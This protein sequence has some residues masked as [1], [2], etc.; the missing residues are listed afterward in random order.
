MSES[1]QVV[2]E[3]YEA[4]HPVTSIVLLP[5]AGVVRGRGS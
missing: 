3:F 5:I 1:I 4:L 2:R